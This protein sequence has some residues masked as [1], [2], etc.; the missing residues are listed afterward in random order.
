MPISVR[1]SVE[2]SYIIYN[3]IWSIR[4]PAHDPW[5]TSTKTQSHSSCPFNIIFPSLA[6]GLL[7]VP[8]F[9]LNLTKFSQE[10]PCQTYYKRN[11]I[12]FMLAFGNSKKT[13]PVLYCRI[14]RSFLKSHY[15]L[16]F[17]R[18]FITYKTEAYNKN[19][20]QKTGKDC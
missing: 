8:I 5:N 9:I 20:Y 14:I 2:E 3:I 11:Y 18:I 19:Q 7:N 16:I 15:K 6:K 10:M 1:F 17:E 12:Q 4:L 13:E